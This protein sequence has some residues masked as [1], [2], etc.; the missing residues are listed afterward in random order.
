MN[1]QSS[2]NLSEKLLLLQ[3]NQDACLLSPQNI[4]NIT[5]KEANRKHVISFGIDYF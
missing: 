1:L 4:I 3:Y 5:R 2:N